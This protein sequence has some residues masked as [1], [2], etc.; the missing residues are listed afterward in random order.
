MMKLK[1]IAK[2]CSLKTSTAKKLRELL[3]ADAFVAGL[4]SPLIRQR[5]LESAEPTLDDLYKTALAMEVAIEDSKELMQPQSLP[6][7]VF[8]A[9]SNNEEFS[10]STSNLAAVSGQSRVVEANIVK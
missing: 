2:K 10:E 3:I 6:N 7:G 4:Q 8:A 1:S 5:L 9:M